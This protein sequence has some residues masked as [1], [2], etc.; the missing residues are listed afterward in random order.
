MNYIP[1]IMLINL[2]LLVVCGCQMKEE[3]LGSKSNPI[4]IYFTPSV[5]SETIAKNA[6]EF[7]SFLEQETG[8]FFKTAIPTSY[9]AVVNAFSSKR[10]D[11]AIMNSFGYM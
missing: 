3:E 6:E 2:M 8:L 11:V 9:L 1:M 5:D 7:N 4:K 10:A